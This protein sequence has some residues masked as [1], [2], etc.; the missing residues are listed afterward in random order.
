MP[1]DGLSKPAIDIQSTFKLDPTD[2]MS[3]NGEYKTIGRKSSYTVVYE[4]KEI[5]P[6]AANKTTI[7]CNIQM[8]VG[9]E[10]CGYTNMS[11]ALN[12]KT[13][14]PMYLVNLEIPKLE[15]P[16]ILNMRKNQHNIFAKYGSSAS[17]SLSDKIKSGSS[18]DSLKIA[19]NMNHKNSSTETHVA[20]SNSNSSGQT[21]KRQS[22]AS[23]SGGISQNNSQNQGESVLHIGEIYKSMVMIKQLRQDKKFNRKNIPNLK[24]LSSTKNRNQPAIGR[25][26]FFDGV[27]IIGSVNST[28][29]DFDA[30]FDQEDQSSD[31][32]YYEHD[33]SRPES[34]YF[35]PSPA[36]NTGN[37][38]F[39]SDKMSSINLNTIDENGKPG[40][41]KNSNYSGKS[42]LSTQNSFTPSALAA[43]PNPVNQNSSSKMNKTTSFFGGTDS[44]HPAIS[45]SSSNKNSST[46]GHQMMKQKLKKPQFAIYYEVVDPTQS[47]A[48]SGKKKGLIR[49]KFDQATK[50]IKGNNNTSN[51][52]NDAI[53]LSKD[54]E[55]MCLSPEPGQIHL[56]KIMLSR[57][58]IDEYSSVHYLPDKYQF[59]NSDARISI[60]KKGANLGKKVKSSGGVGNCNSQAVFM[61]NNR[62]RSDFA[63]NDVSHDVHFSNKFKVVPVV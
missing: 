21:G 4:I 19:S 60:G 6:W 54:I 28:V 8:C 58:Y 13:N 47:W 29:D 44:S 12:V 45:R 31:D 49:I 40:S 35:E 1:L 33:K 26:Q 30:H 52:T 36:K 16:G 14:R 39:G 63:A 41:D 27:S 32:E 22:Q 55:I 7:I 57:V 46:L 53:L 56:P 11:F 3:N 42:K 15:A 34:P 43:S 24:D 18:T 37:N 17:H 9:Y 59:D 20:S 2:E 61:Q 10:E 38:G 5:E 62:S 51:D 25:G 23:S 50:K 48:I